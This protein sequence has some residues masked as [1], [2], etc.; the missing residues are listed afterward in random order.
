MLTLRETDV[1]IEAA[2]MWPAGIADQNWG[3]IRGKP[4]DD[5][6]YCIEQY[7]SDPSDVLC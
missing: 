4:S 3:I 5:Y 2:K 6:C 7:R 1:A